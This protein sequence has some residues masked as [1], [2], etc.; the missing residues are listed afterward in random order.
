MESGRGIRSALVWEDANQGICYR[1]TVLSDFS[2]CP[3]ERGWILLGSSPSNPTF[4]G[5]S[6]SY[7]SRDYSYEIVVSVIAD[8]NSLERPVERGWIPLGGSRSNTICRS[9]SEPV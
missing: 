6:V 8:V 2:S 7:L 3:V 5:W 4:S 9:T 1:V